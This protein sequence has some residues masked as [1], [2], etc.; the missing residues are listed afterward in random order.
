MSKRRA[1]VWAIVGLI[2]L[3]LVNS[4]DDQPQAPLSAK[5]AVNERARG[6]PTTRPPQSREQPPRPLLVTPT[7]PVLVSPAPV[8]PPSAAAAAFRSQRLNTT[9]KVRVRAGPSTS[10]AIVWTAPAGNEVESVGQEDQW[11]RVRVG[12]YE[13]WIRGNFLTED[14]R[15]PPATR[16]APSAPLVRST[17]ARRTGE[18]NCPPFRPDSRHK[19]KGSNL[20]LCKSHLRAGRRL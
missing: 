6:A 16:P 7:A 4:K 11:H 15:K 13:G 3:A 17:P 2:V 5:P 12:P 18:L 10:A 14:Q 20:R 8:D 19:Q 9:A 1:L